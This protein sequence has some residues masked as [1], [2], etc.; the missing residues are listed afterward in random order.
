MKNNILKDIP[1]MNDYRDVATIKFSL[2]KEMELMNTKVQI[3]M[4]GCEKS[5]VNLLGICEIDL[6]CYSES[7]ETHKQHRLKLKLS[8]CDDENA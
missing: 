3:I 2:C 4:I 5:E 7:M 6:G 8:K 1:A